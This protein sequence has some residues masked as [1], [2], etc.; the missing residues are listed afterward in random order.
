MS[1]HTLGTVACSRI[2]NRHANIKCVY[3]RYIFVLYNSLSNILTLSN[4]FL[5]TKNK[6]FVPIKLQKV[7]IQ[8]SIWQLLH[9]NC[10]YS[11]QRA[12]KSGLPDISDT[13]RATLTFPRRSIQEL[14]SWC[15]PSV[16]SR[17][18]HQCVSQGK[19]RHLGRRKRIMG[20]S[21]LFHEIELWTLQR[22]WQETH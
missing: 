2:G 6:S 20:L 13:I 18:P 11:W 3:T 8:Y 22:A 10:M 4:L 1:M 7:L 14:S 21:R 9:N 15:P 5:T 19:G 16:G 12:F 17:I